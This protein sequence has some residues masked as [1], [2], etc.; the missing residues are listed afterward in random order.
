LASQSPEFEEM[1]AKLDTDLDEVHE[2]C[3][4]G[5]F[6]KFNQKCQERFRFQS[7]NLGRNTSNLLLACNATVEARNGQRGT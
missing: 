4:A 3:K 1:V 7:W 6:E 5:K 2:F